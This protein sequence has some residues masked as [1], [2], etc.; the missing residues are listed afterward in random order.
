MKSNQL[1]VNVARVLAVAAAFLSVEAMA[2]ETT[3]GAAKGSVSHQVQR[4]Q[5]DVSSSWTGAQGKTAGRNVDRSSNGTTVATVSGPGGQSATR[6]ASRQN[7]DV[8]SSITGANGQT[9][10]SRSVDRSSTGST[11][12]VTGP[13]GQ[14]A[15]RS[16]TY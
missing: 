10:G 8:N 16:T 15:S 5:G 14:Q 11:A 4:S 1:M 13:N 7:G 3:F 9:Y 6:N 2:R 12:T